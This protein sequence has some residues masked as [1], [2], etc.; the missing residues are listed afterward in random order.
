[1]LLYLEFLLNYPYH[2]LLCSFFSFL[3]IHQRFSIPLFHSNEPNYLYIDLNIL[4]NKMIRIFQFLH[5]L[6]PVI[7]IYTK[8]LLSKYS[9]FEYIFLDIQR[10]LTGYY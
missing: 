7:I 2:R 4:L 3:V 10:D 6:I 9:S 8:R 1:M 5:P